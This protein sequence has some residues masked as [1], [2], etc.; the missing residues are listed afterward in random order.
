LSRVI[1]LGLILKSK[2]YRVVFKKVSHD[3]RESEEVKNIMAVN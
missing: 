3:D 1:D 2:D